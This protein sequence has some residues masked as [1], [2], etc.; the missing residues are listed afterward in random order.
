MEPSL[1]S[2]IFKQIV[3]GVITVGSMFYS[4]IDGVHANF[5]GVDVHSDGKQVLVT[6]YLENCFTDDFDRLFS[7]GKR[8]YFHYRI[9]II[10]AA[11]NSIVQS[12]ELFNAISYSHLDNIYEVYRSHQETLTSNLQIRRAKFLLASLP[13]VPVLSLEYLDGEKIYL[14]K[15]SAWLDRIKLEGMEEP[16]NLMFYWNSIR[17]E[18]ISRPFTLDALN[19]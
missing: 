14:V 3:T 1:L 10:D 18:I 11:D 15:I 8:I 6:T 7:S 4:T 19:L 2:G 9:D 17:P 16:L 13:D 12:K 5:G